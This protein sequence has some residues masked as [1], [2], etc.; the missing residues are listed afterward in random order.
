MGFNRSEQYISQIPK[1]DTLSAGSW[2]K[3][4]VKLLSHVRLFATPWTVA[5]QAP[6]STGSSMQEYWCGLPF[7]HLLWTELCPSPKNAYPEAWTPHVTV[8]RGRAFQE[9]LQVKWDHEG[10]IL[11]G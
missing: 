4:E 3:S 6:L 2:N 9:V 1:E 11:M 8:F 10:G 7:K 5:H